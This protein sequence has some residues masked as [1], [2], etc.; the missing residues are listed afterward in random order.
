MNYFLKFIKK[1]FKIVIYHFWLQSE[2][3]YTKIFQKLIK[4]RLNYHLAAKWRGAYNCFQKF[5]KKIFKN[6]Q[7]PFL[8]A[9]W[10]GVY[11]NLPKN[12]KNQIHIFSITISSCKMKWSILKSS[13]LNMPHFFWQQNMDTST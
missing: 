5:I 8:A 13:I 12:N 11:K 7:L 1:R 3:E 10:S 9:K 6:S 4:I 2:V